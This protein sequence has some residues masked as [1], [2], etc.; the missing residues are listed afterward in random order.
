MYFIFYFLTCVSVWGGEMGSVLSANIMQINKHFNEYVGL[1]LF[2]LEWFVL[3]CDQDKS[4]IREL[5]NCISTRKTTWSRRA[6]GPGIRKATF[7][8]I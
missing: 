5:L 8:R 4:H 2:Y 1:C 3:Y 7:H 6:L